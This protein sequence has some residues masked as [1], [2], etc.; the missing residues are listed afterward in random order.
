MEKNEKELF[1][2]KLKFVNILISA[3]IIQNLK[4]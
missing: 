2:K 4:C 3:S 1:V